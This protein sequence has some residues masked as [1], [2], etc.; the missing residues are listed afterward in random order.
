[1]S[2]LRGRGRP[3]FRLT[4]PLPLHS[5]DETTT[6]TCFHRPC[7]GTLDDGEIQHPQASAPSNPLVAAMNLG[8]GCAVFLIPDTEATVLYVVVL[9]PGRTHGQCSML[10][11]SALVY[12][13]VFLSTPTGPKSSQKLRRSSEH[14]VDERLTGN[15]INRG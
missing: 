15:L 6:P 12:P 8:S 9:N 11:A 14:D 10:W 1:M 2:S 4:D 7:T 13:F 5:R 3:G